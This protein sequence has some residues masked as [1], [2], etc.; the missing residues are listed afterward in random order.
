MQRC[1]E[2]LITIN[3]TPHTTRSNDAEKRFNKAESKLTQLSSELGK[4]NF[5]AMYTKVPYFLHSL[6]LDCLAACVV[7]S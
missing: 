2:T 6:S 1:R 5:H 7:I 4:V 3:P